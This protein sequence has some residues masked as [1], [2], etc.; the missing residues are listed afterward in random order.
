MPQP[1]SDDASPTARQRLR[2]VCWIALAALC[3]GIGVIG[4]FLPL[5]PA[6]D[7]MLLAVFCA[8]RGSRR[9]ELWIR[10]NRLAGPLIQAWEEERAIALPAKIVSLSMMVLSAF[11]IW[12]HTGFNWVFWLFAIVLLAVGAFVASRP[13]PTRRWRRGADLDVSEGTSDRGDSKESNEEH[14]GR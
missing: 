8:S 7:F 14:G 11:V 12:L 2:R 13:L 9:F 6:T 4:I 10:K 3:F 1:P 5:L